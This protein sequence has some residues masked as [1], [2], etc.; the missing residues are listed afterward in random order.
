MVRVRFSL[1]LLV[2]VLVATAAT[3][4][5]ANR[6]WLDDYR[7]LK[8]RMERDY[9]NL[10]WY[11]SPEGGVDLPRLDRRTR[12]ALENAGSVDE[13]RAAIRDFVGALDDGHFSI[14]P[15]AT[16]AEGPAAPEPA[17]RDLDG[18]G[19]EQA[20]AARGYASRSQVA[21]SL[22]FESLP[23]FTL[24]DPGQASSFRTG[25]LRQGGHLIG[26]L[27]I[28]NFS[29]T[30]F[31]AVCVAA[32]AAAPPAARRD[33]SAFA[34]RVQ[35]EWLR[36]LAAA[37]SRLEAAHVDVLIVDVGTNSGGNDSGDWAPRLFT[38]EPLRSARLLMTAGPLA[39]RY[40][41]EE[42]ASLETALRRTADRASRTAGE[43]ALAIMRALRAAAAVPGCDLSW[44]WSERR[45]WQPRGCAR[46]ADVGFASGVLD[47]QPDGAIPDPAVARHVYWPSV[48]GPLRG[49]WRGPTY[50]LVNG[51]TY[52][53]A[54]MFAAVLQNNRAARIV[55]TTSGGDGC[56]FMVDSDPLTLPA[57]G[58]Q[59]RMSNC[60]RLRADGG[61]E[62][63]G[64]T[65]D[66]PVP[67]RRGESARARAA[68]LAAMVA[69]DLDG[70][71]AA[72]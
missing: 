63:A 6:S 18:E 51:T 13:A 33:A 11:A 69:E 55:G 34:D 16:F 59:I 62:V 14:L 58:L 42:I 32:W 43:A 30:Q 27:R 41:D 7:L 25:T 17:Q 67:P 66:L 52:S 70:R 37:I 15:S 19:A 9:A 26:L 5:P 1:L 68:R 72:P 8:A 49:R 44:A 35:A 60:V 36:T 71:R 24:V 45:P 2:A 50:I 23:G 10:A 47:Y 21:F 20:C 65:P 39:A 56:G 4:Q 57:L 31:P 53:S 40:L 64:I 22:P 48:V 12:A 3:A 61:D 46:L 38:A 28:R 29:P 54:E